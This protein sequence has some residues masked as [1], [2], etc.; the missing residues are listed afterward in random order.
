MSERPRPI[1]AG[2]LRRRL[3]LAFA[4]AAGL[5][6]A[7]LAAGSFLLVREARLDDSVERGLDQSRFN[8]V[9]AGEVLPAEGPE[10]LLD[11]L[12]RR[13]G[14]D[15][16]LVDDGRAFPSS[17]SLGEEQVP[18]DLRELVATG[19]LGYEREE[20]GGV[21]YLVTGG[22]VPGVDGAEAYFFFSEQELR[23]DLRELGT[24]LLGGLGVVVALAALAG[25]LLARRTL[26]PVARA[27]AAARSLAEG[28]LETRLP[29]EREDEF[30]AWAASFNEMADALESKIT[31]LSEAQ[32]RERRFSA[33]VAHELRTPLTAI[34][35]EASLLAD[36]MERLPP[37]S[38]RAAE[39][40]VA[41]VA[42]LRDLV[43]DL[44]EISRLDAGTQPVRP[45]RTDL[46]SLVRAAVR[47]RGWEERLRLDAD[48]VVLTSDPRRL[49][50][51]VANLVGNAL[52]HGGRDVAVRV[53]RDGVGAFVEVSDH[54]PGIPR[55]ELPHLFDRFYKADRARAGAGSGLG[56]A[57]A[58]EN[59]RLLGG[60]IDV[61][62][63]PGVGTRFTLRLP[64][65]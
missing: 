14:F 6:A 10:G 33:D 8:L 47:A 34:V 19:Q 50:R 4:L 30:G 41:D 22:R 38:R 54:G 64:V 61:T 40:L 58:L 46:A 44:L 24:I 48:E 5:A 43:E 63:D 27:S 18:G 12:R 7:A 20:S 56:L 29:V 21:H 45:E 32:T 9:L 37:E 15:T 13:G 23:D 1:Q 59:A 52:E 35:N 49:E 26:A 53:G 31:A 60:D 11:A 65:T 3:T 55:E 17:L 42:R 28:L 57:I 36:Q 2:R 39:L 62:S 16:V 51:V 25:A